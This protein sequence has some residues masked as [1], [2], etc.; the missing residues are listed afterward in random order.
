MA[1]RWL[2]LMILVVL[3][4]NVVGA[5]PVTDEQ[6]ICFFFDEEATI[7]SFYGSGVVVGYIVV[8]P[9]WID[10]QRVEV[11]QRWTCTFSWHAAPDVVDNCDVWPLPGLPG[12]IDVTSGS[13]DI[14]VECHIPLP[15]GGPTVV[16]MVGFHLTAPE[17]VAIF[18]F[19]WQFWADGVGPDSFEM[20][21]YGPDGP[22]DTTFYV[23]NINGLA[24]VA[25]AASTW[26]QIKLMYR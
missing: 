20:L 2:K 21:T 11:L 10:G 3:A 26:E 14:D 16:A 4:P 8:N 22:M 17:P 15:A 12:E 25:V 9:L 23:A 19:P 7:R 6:T 1:S 5:Q 18:I 24:P 13:A